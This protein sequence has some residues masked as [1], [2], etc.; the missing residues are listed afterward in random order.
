M[1]LEGVIS[2]GVTLLLA[3]QSGIAAAAQAV[4]PGSANPNHGRRR[5]DAAQLRGRDVFARSHRE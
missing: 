2:T 1:K 4:V 3:L 5:R